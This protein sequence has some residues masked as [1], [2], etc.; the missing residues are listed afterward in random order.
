MMIPRIPSSAMPSIAPISSRWL[1]SFSIA[2]GSTRSS[3]NERTVSWISRC[4]S[5]SSKSTKRRLYARCVLVG[6]PH[7]EQAAVVRDEV[8]VLVLRERRAHGGDDQLVELRALDVLDGRLVEVRELRV[9]ELA[10]AV[11]VEVV[12]GEC[13]VPVELLGVGQVVAV[14]DLEVG[15]RVLVDAHPAA[16]DRAERAPADERLDRP[17]E[18]VV[19]RRERD[20]RRRVRVV[21]RIDDAVLHERLA[22]VELPAEERVHE[23]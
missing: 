17:R 23:P 8:L 19:Q 2:T 1:M 4:S 15:A 13:A 5:L 7:G 12:L 20:V 9:A 22:R 6:D 21:D 3:T 18:V 14:T 10:V 11:D 16:L